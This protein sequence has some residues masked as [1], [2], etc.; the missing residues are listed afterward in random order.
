[1]NAIDAGGR[2]ITAP[3]TAPNRMT[4]AKAWP[5]LVETVHRQRMRIEDTA[6]TIQCTLRAP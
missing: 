6:V 3:E 4:N 1:M 5:K 2:P